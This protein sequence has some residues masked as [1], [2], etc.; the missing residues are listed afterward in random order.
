MNF[1]LVFENS[2]DT[3]PFF[4]DKPDLLEYFVNF[5]NEKK[6]NGFLP[7]DDIFISQIQGNLVKLS[8]ALV[9]YNQSLGTLFTGI[10]DDFNNTTKDKPLQ[11]LLNQELLN[12]IHYCWVKSHSKYTTFSE[13]KK[14]NI[15]G[16][17]QHLLDQLP[18]DNRK[19]SAPELLFKLGLDK[20]YDDINTGVH[21]VE[22][23]FD[24][25]RFQGNFDRNF[26]WVEIDNPFP[27]NYTNNNAAQLNIA[28]QHYGR[29]LHD[30]FLY[31][32][33]TTFHDDENNFDQLLGFVDFY[34]LPTET[35]PYSKEYVQW[36]KEIGKT[37]AGN[38]LNIGW[39]E[40]LPEQLTTC[41]QI[42]YRNVLNKNRFEIV[43]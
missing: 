34:L 37:P 6:V 38:N 10:V 30:K 39:I 20:I 12:E 24:R 15:D 2:G 5:L 29:S 17:L 4:T 22:H 31:Q 13:I 14:L 18:D 16:R 21:S 40:N 1:E 43:I 7:Q 3:I 36:C 35:L 19:I 41:R 26:E 9:E 23:C 28:Y 25:I 33:G 8:N 32:S 27:R 11:Y 42:V